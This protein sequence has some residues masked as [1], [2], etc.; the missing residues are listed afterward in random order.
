MQDSEVI[1]SVN[2]NASAPIFDASTYGIVGDLFKV[3]P[4]LTE[5]IAKYKAAKA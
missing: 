4:M 5:A 1:I 3:G 2:K